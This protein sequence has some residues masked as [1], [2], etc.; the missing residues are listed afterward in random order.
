LDNNLFFTNQVIYVELK[1]LKYMLLQFMFQQIN[2]LWLLIEGKKVKILSKYIIIKQ[3]ILWNILLSIFINEQ[4]HSVILFQAK[5]K[6]S[7]LYYF[8][9]TVIESVVV[10]YYEIK[11]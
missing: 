9:F 8:L 3:E 6:K 1:C 5:D 11:I 2:F 7:T 10:C 4:N